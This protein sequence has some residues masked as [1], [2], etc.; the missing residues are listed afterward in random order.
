M[1]AFRVDPDR[2]AVLDQLRQYA[3]SKGVQ[4]ILSEVP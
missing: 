2:L 1:G 3:M 4:L